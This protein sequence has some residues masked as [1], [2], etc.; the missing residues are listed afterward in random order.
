MA[1]LDR[2]REDPPT[3]LSGTT[4]VGQDSIAGRRRSIMLHNAVIFFVVAIIA[5]IFGLSV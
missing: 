4:G 2:Y 5:A 1:A 3:E